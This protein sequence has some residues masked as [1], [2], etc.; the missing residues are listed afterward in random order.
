M[1]EWFILNRASL[2]LIYGI[3]V[4]L[5]CFFIVFRTDKLFRLS[6][7]Q[8]IRYFRNAF[9]FFG[10]GFIL[11][12][13][14]KPNYIFSKYLFEFFL[15]MGGFF[16]F[17]SLIWKKFEFS[18]KETRS[19]LFNPRAII[20]YIM[21]IV[22][23]VL[24]YF[25]ATYC[26]MFFSQIIL[27]LFVTFISYFNYVNKKGKFLKYYFIS[28]LMILV[29]WILNLLA[30]LTFNWDPLVI[31]ITYLLNVIIFVLFFIGI[32]RFTS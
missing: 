14:L 28:A 15:V 11:R 27:F 3:F 17:Y 9:L 24:D 18:G 5:I 31:L 10:V 16:L 19:S 4:A 21:A 7:H 2:K 8:G 1:I 26:F 12:Y 13:I 29:A 20:F 30:S 6:F 23:T 32:L 22:V 25:W